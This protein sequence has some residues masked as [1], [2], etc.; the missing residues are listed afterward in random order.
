MIRDFR[1]DNKNDSPNP[2]PGGPEEEQRAEKWSDW[3]WQL[4]SGGK[5][6]LLPNYCIGESEAGMTLRNFEGHI[7]RVEEDQEFR[8]LAPVYAGLGR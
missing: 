2:E 6:P 8:E 7:Y 1:M 3:K 5:I 4:K